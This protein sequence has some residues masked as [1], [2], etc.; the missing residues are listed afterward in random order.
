M[1]ELFLHY[2]N[3]CLIKAGMRNGEWKNEMGN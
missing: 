1:S 3:G 2:L